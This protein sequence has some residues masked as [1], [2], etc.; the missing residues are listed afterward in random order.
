VEIWELLADPQAQPRRI[1]AATRLEGDAQFVGL[2][3]ELEEIWE[4]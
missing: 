1:E 3:L 4:G 2:G